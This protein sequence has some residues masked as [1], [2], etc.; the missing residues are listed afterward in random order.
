M[1][2]KNIIIHKIFIF[3][4]FIVVLISFYFFVDAFICKNV[5]HLQIFNAWQFP[6]LLAIYVDTLYR[7]EL[8]F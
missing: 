5:K 4:L 1:A 7:L 6:M 8:S 3:L 2:N